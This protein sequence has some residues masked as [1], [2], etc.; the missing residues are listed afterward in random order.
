MIEYDPNYV[1]QN[2]PFLLGVKILITNDADEVL[3]LWRSAK[4][5]RPHGIDLPGGAVDAGEG[6]EQAAIREVLEETGIA[7]GSPRIVGAEYAPRRSGDAVIVGYTYH[8]EGEVP[9]VTISWEHESY[10]WKPIRDIDVENLPSLH[11]RLF[12]DWQKIRTQ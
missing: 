1:P 11:A 5:S 3:V 7:I 9:P 8:I 12:R 4:V 10:E 2:A 6:P